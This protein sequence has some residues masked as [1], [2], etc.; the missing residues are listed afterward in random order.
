TS[1][2][3]SLFP[4]TTLF[5]SGLGD[6]GFSADGKWILSTNYSEITVM[7]LGGDVVLSIDRTRPGDPISDT[8]VGWINPSGTRLVYAG[9][10]VDRSEEHTS[11]LQSRGHLV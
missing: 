11:E 4:Y 6:K 10:D 5:R 2:V 7:D 9:A 1:S 8:H 3:A